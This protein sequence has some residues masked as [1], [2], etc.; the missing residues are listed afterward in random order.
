MVNLLNLDAGDLH[1]EKFTFAS[2]PFRFCHNW[3]GGPIMLYVLLV[4][5]RKGMKE[6]EVEGGKYTCTLF[7][8]DTYRCVH[9]YTQTPMY[10]THTTVTRIQIL[11]TRPA[12]GRHFNRLPCRL[13]G[14]QGRSRVTSHRRFTIMSAAPFIII[15][16]FVTS[17]GIGDCKYTKL[18]LLL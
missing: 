15:F 14:E 16:F 12:A 8:C 3:G 10:Y 7:T 4:L 11:H 18:I 2:L 17:V 1:F 9:I 13:F 5:D 6:K